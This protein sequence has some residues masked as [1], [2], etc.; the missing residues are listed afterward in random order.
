MVPFVYP[1][2]LWNSYE[3]VQEV[4]YQDWEST[5]ETQGEV[6]RWQSVSGQRNGRGCAPPCLK[7]WTSN[8]KLDPGL[9]K[10]LD[11]VSE[12]NFHAILA[13]SS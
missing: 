12:R 10:G 4:G 3:T 9:G 8:T 2:R 1:N 7:Q 6:W 13:L 11:G 5:K